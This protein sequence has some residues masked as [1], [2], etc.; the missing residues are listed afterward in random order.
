[1]FLEESY[2]KEKQ[3]VYVR[4]EKKPLNLRYYATF[5]LKKKK[6]C[7]NHIKSLLIVN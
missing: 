4:K 6:K 5:N 7:L 1:M 3:Q 2:F